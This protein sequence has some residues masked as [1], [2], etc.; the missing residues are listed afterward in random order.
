ML[1]RGAILTP[2][3]RV[4]AIRRIAPFADGPDDQRR[5]PVRI[6]RGKNSRNAGAVRQVRRN[7]ATRIQ[8]DAEIDKQSALN[9]PSESHRQ[10]YQIR[11]QLELAT[12]QLHVVRAPVGEKLSLQTHTVDALHATVLA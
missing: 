5:P 3:P 1:D 6:T 7:C 2:Q 12:R 10:Q 11:L 8:L 9:R 4:N